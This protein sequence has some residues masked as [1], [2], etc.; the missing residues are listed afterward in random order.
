MY[1]ERSIGEECGIF[2]IWGHKDAA[3]LTYYGLHAMQHRG[4]DGA[5]IIVK[6]MQK[7]FGIKGR[8]LLVEVFDDKALDDLTGDS[9]LGHVLYATRGMPESS[10]I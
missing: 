6:N 5:G 7:L 9:A 8:G 4:Q 3:R 1:D 2:G 10:E